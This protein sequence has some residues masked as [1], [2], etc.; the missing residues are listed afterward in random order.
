MGREK[1]TFKAR[2]KRPGDEVAITPIQAE[3]KR[4]DVV[5]IVVEGLNV[6]TTLNV[7]LVPRASPPIF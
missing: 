3:T 1:A 2:E 5:L 7:N 6:I 4:Y